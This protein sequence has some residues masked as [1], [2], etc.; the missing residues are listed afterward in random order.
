MCGALCS[1]Y[2]HDSADQSCAQRTQQ[3]NHL[4]L[5]VFNRRGYGYSSANPGWYPSR[6]HASRLQTDE[7]E[8]KKGNA[9][10]SERALF[11]LAIDAYHVPWLENRDCIVAQSTKCLHKVMVSITIIERCSTALPRFDAIPA[12]ITAVF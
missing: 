6:C 12:H 8:D 9:E 4:P 2:L 3:T 5:L 7:S 10:E 11:L 1:T